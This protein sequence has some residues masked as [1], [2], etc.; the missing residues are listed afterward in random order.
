MMPLSA[1][2]RAL[3]GGK[4]GFALLTVIAVLVPGRSK[5]V[6]LKIASEKKAVRV[7]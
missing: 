3:V 4:P 2:H 1:R 7:L 5:K 6:E